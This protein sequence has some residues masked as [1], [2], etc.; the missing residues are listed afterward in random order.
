M[1]RQAHRLCSNRAATQVNLLKTREK[2]VR[3]KT[4]FCRVFANSSNP[5]QPI[6]LPSHGRG[7]W[8][9]PSIAHSGKTPLC[10]KNRTVRASL[11]SVGVPRRSL[12]ADGRLKAQRFRA[13]LP[14]RGCGQHP[15]VSKSVRHRTCEGQASPLRPRRVEG[16]FIELGAGRCDVPIVR[17]L[18]QWGCECADA[19]A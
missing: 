12:P 3:R 4:V 18:V 5:Q 9:E 10:R 13:H 2:C 16:S 8:F 17:R 14:L 6:V 19:F 1:R 7:R 15:I 11:S